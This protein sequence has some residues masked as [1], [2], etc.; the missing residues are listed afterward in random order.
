MSEWDD[1]NAWGEDAGWEEDV[2][3]QWEDDQTMEDQ[4]W[5]DT[6]PDAADPSGDVPMQSRKIQFETISK[7]A[8]QEQMQGHIAEFGE[9]L[10]VDPPF[11]EA[12]LLLQYYEWDASRATSEYFMG[13]Q[14]LT[15]INA[16]IDAATDVAMMSER[17]TYECPC[18]LDDFPANQVASLTCGHQVCYDCWGD[19]IRNA[20]KTR[21]CF[22]LQCPEGCCDVAATTT[23]LRQIGINPALCADLEKRQDRFQLRNYVQ[24]SKDLHMCLGAD[25]NY[26]Q[27]IFDRKNLSDILC[28]A[29]GHVYCVKCSQNGHRPCPCDVAD[30]W[31]V[32]ATSEAENMQWI[33]AKTKKCPKCRVP[34]EKNQGCNHM[35]CRNCR[36]E[37]CWL[38]KGD[39]KEHGSATGGFYKCNVY[40]KRKNEGTLS[41]EE[42]VQNDAKSELER[43]GF[44]FTRY[45]NHIKAISQM[46]KTLEEAESRMGE[47]MSAYKWKPNEA[48]FI[49]DAAVTIQDCRRL[50]AWTYPIGYYMEESFLQRDLFHQY[51]KDLEVYTEHLHELVE[52]PLETFKDNDKRA[53]VINY[54]RVLQKYRDKLVT[55]IEG[56][57]NPSCK[58]LIPS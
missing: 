41:S 15:R 10:G 23:R 5:E 1:D 14:T 55:A 42:R 12:K 32:K 46:K 36:Y 44:Y 20:A 11:E 53:E 56:E 58:F 34:I 38:C 13:D 31:I 22:K 39:W 6:N 28:E 21:N 49:K 47:L 37:F 48:S 16:G 4:N 45:D 24:T 18:C 51:Q 43:Y 40:E 29:C 33:L 25:C 8:I 9:M 27:R 2:Q 7:L 54:Q 35:T 57:V 52:Q 19:Y 17:D 26:V 3:T 30:A 50:L